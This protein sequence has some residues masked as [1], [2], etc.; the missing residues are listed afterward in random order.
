M[1]PYNPGRVTGR[2]FLL[3]HF[4]YWNLPKDALGDSDSITAKVVP[5]ERDLLMLEPVL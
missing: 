2:G 4:W 1:M 3:L 5:L